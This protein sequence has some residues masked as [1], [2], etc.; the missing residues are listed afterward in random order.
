MFRKFLKDIRGNYIMLTAISMVPIMGGLAIAID[1]TE[2]TRQR[3]LTMAALDGPTTT[4]AAARSSSRP[5]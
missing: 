2:L 4:S 1:Y 3:S 5:T